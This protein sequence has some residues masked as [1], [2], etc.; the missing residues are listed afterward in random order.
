M[1]RVLVF[2][3]AAALGAVLYATSAPAGQQ[4]SPTLAQFNALKAKVAKLQKNAEA[5]TV[6]VGGCLTRAVPV[7]QYDGYAVTFSDGTTG[8]SSALDVAATG[9]TPDAYMLDV[10]QTCAQ[11]LGASGL[12]LKIVRPSATLRR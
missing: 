11:A 8:Q 6:V 2:V 12:H 5:V 10:G 1:R 7:A 4:A 3:A 9:D